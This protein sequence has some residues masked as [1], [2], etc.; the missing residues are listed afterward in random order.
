MD[1]YG[2][3]TSFQLEELYEP[4]C[5]KTGLRGFRQG[6]TQS[7]LCNHR[8]CLGA[9]NYGFRKKWYCTIRSVNKGADQ[10]RQC[11]NPVFS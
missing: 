8:I 2:T 9:W 5:E 3:N 4:R 10:L 7:G 11:K 1:R 6:P